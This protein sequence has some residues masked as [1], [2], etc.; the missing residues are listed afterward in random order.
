MASWVVDG[1]VKTSGQDSNVQAGL[2]AVGGGVGLVVYH[3]PGTIWMFLQ[4]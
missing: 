4:K 3:F 2:G 1:V